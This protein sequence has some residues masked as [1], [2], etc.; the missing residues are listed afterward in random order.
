L[1]PS[2]TWKAFIVTDATTYPQC[3]VKLAMNVL[4][5]AERG[6]EQGS[7]GLVR[8][9]SAGH[10]SACNGRRRRELC[11]RRRDRPRGWPHGG[12]CAHLASLKTEYGPGNLFRLNQNVRLN[13]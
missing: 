1:H 10:R 3:D 12:N 6:D 4:Q 11:A 5:G 13:A 7:I 8:E 9:L 2:S